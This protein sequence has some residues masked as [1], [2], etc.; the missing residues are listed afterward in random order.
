M[1]KSLLLTIALA[2]FTQA[3]PF[4]PAV[5]P[6]EQGFNAVHIFPDPVPSAVLADNDVL[7]NSGL[8]AIKQES[9]DFV[10]KLLLSGLLPVL[11]EPGIVMP[12]TVKPHRHD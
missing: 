10:D 1:L 2:T 5:A 7:L 9:Q 4:P 3:F 6:T 12:S 8:Q 11:Q